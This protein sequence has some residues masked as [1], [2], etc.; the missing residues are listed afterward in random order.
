[1]IG[2]TAPARILLATGAD[3]VRLGVYFGTASDAVP[4]GVT[5]TR[6]DLPRNVAPGESVTLTVTL[7]GA[8]TTGNYTFWSG[9]HSSG[10]ADPTPAGGAGKI[11]CFVGP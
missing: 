9:T 8:A 5:P 2:M 1:M 11:Y 4:A 7:A 3:R 6:V 10:C